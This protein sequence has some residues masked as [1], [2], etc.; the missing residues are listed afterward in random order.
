MPIIRC[1]PGARRSPASRSARPFTASPAARSA[2]S[3]G[4]VL[5]TAWGFSDAA[6]IALAIALAFFFGYA[7]TSIPLLRAGFAFAA[8]IPIAL[9]ADTLS[10][11]TMEVVDNAILLAIPG[12][13]EA[14]LD[15]LLFWGSLAFALAIAFVV[16]VPVNRWLIARGKGH[17]ALHETGVHGGPPIWLVGTATAIA[18]RLRLGRTARRAARLTPSPSLIG[19]AGRGYATSRVHRVDHRHRDRRDRRRRLDRRPASPPRGREGDRAPA[20]RQARPAPIAIRPTRTSPAPRTSVARPSFTAARP[21]ST[22]PG[23]RAHRRRHEHAEQAASLERKVETA[24]QAAARH[25]E[26][27]AEREQKLDANPLPRRESTHFPLYASQSTLGASARPGAP[28]PG[29]V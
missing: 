16:T 6:T 21:R 18:G 19:S 4:V 24:G 15:T 9:A 28:S 14:G 10:I 7:L 3:L 29:R 26:Q 1:R 25:D 13:M 22:R 12:A 20:S 17:M 27:A 5:G 8:V 2:R 11:A 23:R